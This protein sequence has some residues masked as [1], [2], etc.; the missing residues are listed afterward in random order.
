MKEDWISVKD[1]LPE[2]HVQVLAMKELKNG[3]RDYCLAYCIREYEAWDY[4]TGQNKIGPYWVC[5]GN[6]NILYWMPLPDI[7]E[8]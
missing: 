7:P 6:N 4:K 8:K 2:D 5:G 3:R 1:Q